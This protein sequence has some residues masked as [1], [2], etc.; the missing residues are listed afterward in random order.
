MVAQPAGAGPATNGTA[1][2]VAA[3]A[4]TVKDR[5]VEMPRTARNETTGDFLGKGYDQRAVVEGTLG[6]KNLNIYDS[7][8]RWGAAPVDIPPILNLAVR[9]SSSATNSLFRLGRRG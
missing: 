8:A 1:G 5:S 6:D 4:T 2:H 3:A 7:D 9:N